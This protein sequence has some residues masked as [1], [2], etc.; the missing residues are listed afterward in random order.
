MFGV[1]MA[2]EIDYST[3]VRLD[4]GTVTPS[5]AGPK[6]PQDRIEIGKVASTF[7]SLFS[8]PIGENGF[9]QP[10]ELLQT[11]HLVQRPATSRSASQ[12]PD[13]PPAPW[14]RRASW[15]RWRPTSRPALAAHAM[16]VPHVEV[17]DIT[18][19][20]G[21][22]LIA[23]I[24]SCTNTSN[25]GRAA[26]GRPAG[27]E[28]GGEGP[29]GPAA[30]QDLARARLAHRHRVPAQG[31]AAALPRAAGLH[32]RRLRLH[33]LHRQLRRPDAGDQRG[34]QPE[35]PGVRRGALGQ[36][37]LRGAHPPE[38][39]GQLPRQPAAGGGLRARRHG[40]QGPDDRAGGQGADGKDVCLGD[41]WPT[42][43][44]V[45]QADEV[46]DERPRRSAPT[47]AR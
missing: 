39:Q 36:P 8:K 10:A 40:A 11:R 21:D 33:D 12:P 18:I 17:G 3:V 16:S 26:G 30:H 24:T 37:Q 45:Q 41:I 14:P 5:L 32:A 46:R 28:G 34:D 42:S 6:R 13:N 38:P 15:W 19:G 7:K 23:A 9:N 22:V 31:G 47:T 44:E 2:G 1:P 25:P 29:D 35:R 43:D 20:N 4:L 27:Q